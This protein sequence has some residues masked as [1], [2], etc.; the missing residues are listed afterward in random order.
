MRLARH[1]ALATAVLAVALAAPAT[2]PALDDFFVKIDG[3][4]SSIP[5]GTCLDCLPTALEAS[6]TATCTMCTAGLP[7][8]GH[9]TLDLGVVTYPPSS[10]RVK[11]VEGT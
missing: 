7:T 8:A 3:I 6:G 2:A 5:E 9:F 10:C 11:S 1:L 4:G